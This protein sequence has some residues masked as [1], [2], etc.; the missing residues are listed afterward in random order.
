MLE[1]DPVLRGLSPDL[2][3]KAEKILHTNSELK[4]QDY[5]KSKIKRVLDYAI[6][7][8]ASLVSLP[9]IAAGGVAVFVGDGC[10]SWPYVDVGIKNVLDTDKGYSF[11]KIRTMVPGAKEMEMEVAPNGIHQL[12]RDNSD[13]RITKIG[14]FLRSF[15]TDELPQFLNVLRG[16]ISLV[17]VRPPTISD[18]NNVILANGNCSVEPY[19][20]FI[21]QVR[22]GEVV[23]GVTGM[24]VICGRHELKVQDQIALEIAYTKKASLIADLRIIRET[25][26]VF[27][28]SR[29][30]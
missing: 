28:K 12:K 15:N 27:F 16:D 4:G 7:G 24:Y 2:A 20:S 29:G 13:S 25:P 18:W 21:E 14:R 3:Q 19:K 9:I 23:W 17:G 8:P 26:K 5:L 10:W 22:S 6:A 30:K 11:W 1:M